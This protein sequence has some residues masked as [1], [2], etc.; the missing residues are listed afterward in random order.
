[1]QKELSAWV[2]W[3]WRNENCLEGMAYTPLSIVDGLGYIYGS[4]MRTVYF[5]FSLSGDDLELSVYHPREG[6]EPTIDILFNDNWA[7][8]TARRKNDALRSAVVIL[9]VCLGM[10]DAAG[11]ENVVWRAA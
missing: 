11:Y 6:E 4:T 5:S 2:D 8:R 7:T 10:R 3:N 9:E 1:M